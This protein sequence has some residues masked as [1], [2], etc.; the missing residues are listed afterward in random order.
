MGASMKNHASRTRCWLLTI[1]LLAL[2]LAVPS[3]QAQFVY[4][5]VPGANEV[6]VIDGSRNTIVDTIGVPGPST[7]AITPD[8]R[9]VYVA[10]Q[11]C[12][13]VPALKNVQGAVSVIDAVSNTVVSTIT[14]P[15]CPG[16]IAIAP[17]GT[18]VYV[19]GDNS[20]FSNSRAIYVIDPSNNSI[21]TS[22]P[23]P[24]SSAGSLT[25]SPDGSR[26]FAGGDQLMVIST[27][28]NAV[29]ARV[30][31]LTFG[32]PCGV[33]EIALTP[34]ESQI[35]L[36]SCEVVHVLDGNT[37]REL[38]QKSAA[39]FCTT[40]GIVITP[41]GKTVFVPDAECGGILAINTANLAT[42]VFSLP[43]ANEPTEENIAITPDS[44]RAFAST[45]NNCCGGGQEVEVFDPVSH[46]LIT[47][48]P[49]LSGRPV[50]IALDPT[51]LILKKAATPRGAVH[52]GDQITYRLHIYNG[53]PNADT[54]VILTD[55]LPAQVQ[56]V[57]A[58]ITGGSCGG[59]TTV[60]CTVPLLANHGTATATIVVTT[61]AAGL[62]RN[63]ATVIGDQPEPFPIDNIA[64]VSNDVRSHSDLQITKFAAP[65]V[66]PAA[67]SV[68]TYQ[69]SIHNNG[70]DAVSDAVVT[71]ALP[72]GLTL[73]SVT[74]SQGT[75]DVTVVCNL[76]AMSSGAVATV[77]IVVIPQSNVQP[78]TQISNTAM[79]NDAH[80]D[81]PDLTNNSFT[82]VVTCTYCLLVKTWRDL[83]NDW[84][85]KNCQNGP[86][87]D[88]T[89]AYIFV[90]YSDVKSKLTQQNVA[91]RVEYIERYYFQQSACSLQIHSYKV[92]GPSNGWITLLQ[93]KA[94]YDAIPMGPLNNSNSNLFVEA[95][96]IWRDAF[97][98]AAGVDPN[99]LAQQQ[100]GN[101]AAVVVVTADPTDVI[102]SRAFITDPIVKNP[103]VLAT[104]GG[105]LGFGLA[106]LGPAL[107]VGA[108]ALL[109]ADL[110]NTLPDT[111]FRQG[112]VITTD[113][114]TTETWAHELGHALFDFW[115]YYGSGEFFTHGDVR[116]WSLM[117]NPHPFTAFFTATSRNDLPGNGPP[118]P[119]MSY[120]RANR[121]WVQYQDLQ[122]G[123]VGE[124]FIFPLGQIGSTVLR[125]KPPRGQTDWFIIEGRQPPDGVPPS[126]DQTQAALPGDGA[127]AGVVIYRKR[128][129]RTTL[130]FPTRVPVCAPGTPRGA[131]EVALA[132]ILGDEWGS[133][134]DVVQNRSLPDPACNAALDTCFT[135]LPGTT[136]ADDDAGVAFSLREDAHGRLF[137]TISDTPH[138]RTLVT[139]EPA[140]DMVFPGPPGGIVGDDKPPLPVDLHVDAADGSHVG[141]NSSTQ[142]FETGITDARSSGPRTGY[143]WIS[144]P[145]NMP[146][147]YSVD[148]SDA[149]KNALAQSLTALNITATVTIYHYD[150]N[151]NLTTLVQPV[152]IK[153]DLTHGNS[154]PVVIP[155]VRDTIPPTT[156]SMVSPAPN[157]NGWNNSNP[158][159]TL[160]AMDE[161]GGSGVKQITYSA[162]GA[163][164]IASTVVNG[165]ST[166]IVISAEGTTT[167]SF[168][169]T[170][171][172][173][174][175]EVPKTVTIKLD[176][177][178]PTSQ[179]HLLPTT[180]SA[181]SF[182]VQWSGAD[183]GAGIQDFTIFV[184]DN[185][186]PF[187]PFQTNTAATSATFTGQAGH[188]YGFYSISRDLAGN[189]EAAKSVAESTTLVVSCVSNLN[190]RGTPSGRAP[191]R[192][193]VT[194]TG[195]PS[196]VSYNVLRG[197]VSGGPYTLLGKTVLPAFSDTNGLVNGGTY[198][199]V[200]QPINSAGGVICQSNEATIAI[201]NQ[202]R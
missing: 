7:I 8:T 190:G 17:D 66:L 21:V 106:L 114:N 49:V 20:D 188:T 37:Y 71:D 182:T 48:I 174:N 131:P 101:F 27:A 80:N 91:D 64:S 143:Q 19:S 191:A 41:D 82:A 40:G 112:S 185:G 196:A 176:K 151:A 180:E 200:V 166:S 15:N 138:S 74:P 45:F 172:A 171:N 14:L 145:D 52:L 104:A 130:G 160:M 84:D 162:S 116:P 11:P 181:S 170:D 86:V 152:Q 85:K 113:V 4:V 125:Y 54:K 1:S 184:S 88:V 32:I 94:Q 57:S 105:V 30:D 6:L 68:L 194:W 28:T 127:T 31:V 22:I 96:T 79:V 60:V 69:L 111:M 23:L 195:I 146:V 3:A 108:A 55:T 129:I 42:S 51:G 39:G 119:V 29:V 169:A 44:R 99:F 59:T 5:T 167:V 117:S 153:L 97:V 9:Y 198:Y 65:S 56:F 102:R 75:C 134:V 136:Y 132:V 140:A 67:G 46:N 50:N 53:G 2:G 149:I 70:P 73:S 177:T 78:T 98:A 193:D 139:M 10:Q 173:G 38:A 197:T 201:P 100:L 103:A 155:V 126:P 12:P 202:P 72:M 133:C 107:P 34:D 63:T 164:N 110:V 24:G 178:P 142:H 189:V 168:F 154:G 118:A 199:Y 89:V 124:Y 165:A 36:T 128:E 187:A 77:T 158:T 123:D 161:S 157:A 16:E 62:A 135:L 58:S 156:A 175:I 186:G 120:N 121:G 87:Q 13:F 147:S 141:W 76:G 43:G 148:A 92:N 47:S 26:L 137:V 192:I 179:V 122:P 150:S 115:D 83:F 81:D 163:Q 159:V 144:F 33:G 109:P 90:Q 35:Y 183:V 93:T 25:I 95:A 18:R 61:I